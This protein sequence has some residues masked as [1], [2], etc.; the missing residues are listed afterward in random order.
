MNS[1]SLKTAK[2]YKFPVQP[3][4]RAG[5]NPLAALE[6]EA[7]SYGMA[8]FGSGWYHDDAIADASQKVWRGRK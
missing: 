1:G 7:R 6:A 8:D 3:R 5:L 2:I 4:V